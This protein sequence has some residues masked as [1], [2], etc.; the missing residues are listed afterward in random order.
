MNRNFNFIATHLRHGQNNEHL[1]D[2]MA[3]DLIREFKLQ[4]IQNSVPSLECDQFSDICFFMGDMN[5]RM[6]TTFSQFNNKNVA[7]DAVKMV[8][9]YD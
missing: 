7:T 6:N 2:Q 8:P 9:T 5:Y 3:S 4:A 1:R